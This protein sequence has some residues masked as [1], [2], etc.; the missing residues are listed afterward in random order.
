[1]SNYNKFIQT[2]DKQQLQ[3]KQQP[4]QNKYTLLSKQ[5][6]Q[7]KQ[8]NKSNELNKEEMDNLIK[9]ILMEYETYNIYDINMHI[10][11]TGYNDDCL[12]LNKKKST[13]LYNH[14]IYNNYAVLNEYNNII[15]ENDVILAKKN[16]FISDE[17]NNLNDLLKIIN[18]YPYDPLHKYNINLKA[19]HNINAPLQKLNN[20]IGMQNLKNNI[21]D[22]LLY[23]IQEFHIQPSNSNS[24]GDYM[25][26]II[27]GQPG[28]GKTEIAKILGSIYSKLGILTKGTFK[29]VT[30]SDLI[31]GY[32]GQTAIK[33][34]NV[35]KEALGGVLFIDEAY[36]LGNSEKQDSFSKECIDTLC[37]ALSDHKDN[38]MVIVAGY[39]KE[40]EQCFF[41]YNEGLNSRFVWRF[42]TDDYTCEDLYNIF[43]KM[44]NDIEWSIDKTDKEI[45]S[46]WFNK[47]KEYFLYY[48][49]DI[50]TFISKIKIAHSKRVFG[51]DISLK[52]K[53]T[54][55]DLDNGLKLY[56]QNKPIT[57]NSLRKEILNGMYC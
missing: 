37:E 5:S 29:K 17:I 33:T 19:L 24:S 9:N 12:F 42:K 55:D 32:L 54:K 22:Q 16:I 21:L 56:L 3:N 14:I 53:I 51:K 39:E 1:M 28:T 47:N 8:S 30:R 50:E 23:F 34:S 44:I 11:S 43:V 20:M 57:N 6:N 49:R 2:L 15:K 52:K 4:I 26:T 38:L 18:K 40:L 25:H 41:N 13:N 35:I 10:S 46:Q 31:A 7:S 48:G 27:Y 45:N 36:A